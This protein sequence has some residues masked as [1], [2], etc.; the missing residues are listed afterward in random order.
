MEGG[1]PTPPPDRPDGPDGPP[2]RPTPPPDGPPLPGP[3]PSEP[4]TGERRTRPV[5]REHAVREP[6]T[7]E[8]RAI[9]QRRRRHRDLPAKVRRRQAIAAGV[10]ALLVIFG[11]YKLISSVFGS[12]DDEPD[13]PIAVEKLIGQTIIGKL[14]AS[15]PD[16]ALLKRVRKG[17][18]GGLI[19][20]PRSANAL[21]RQTTKLQEAAEAGDNPPLLIA[22]D[23]EGGPVERLKGP[24][25]VSPA[26]LGKNGD[27]GAAREEGKATGEF[28]SEVG[29]NVDF[30]PV[31]DVSHPQAA[32][33]LRT[34]TFGDDP[35]TVASMVVAF[36][37]GLQEGGMDPTVKHFPGLGYASTNTDFGASRIDEPR[38]NIETDLEP[39]TQAIDAGVPLVMTST[40]I[41]TAF[42]DKNPAAWSPAL[43][44]E[45]L[46]QRLGFKGVIVTDDL[47]GAAVGKQGSPEEAARKTLL[48]GGDMVLFATNPGTSLGAFRSLSRAA[49]RDA[50]PRER[51]EEAYE[52]ILDLK[53]GF[54]S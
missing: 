37:E 16:K 47:E 20:S 36:S 4:T 21:K 13:A 32:K 1:P 52:R 6:T 51:L 48:A 42:D 31:A 49:Q 30:A 34:R 40:A 45:E 24:P 27:D 8:R 50:L 22:I 17:Q 43:L 53:D 41:Y 35:E 28:L 33:T 38:G 19:V 26:E 54:G 44:D 46:R 7:A 12:D 9:S 23:Q 25:D 5:T 2:E 11:A 15:G 29:V 18:I 10:L 14:P 3:P 39:F